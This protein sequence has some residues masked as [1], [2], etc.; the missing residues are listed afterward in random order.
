MFSLKSSW[1]VRLN[2]LQEKCIEIQ[3]EILFL[4]VFSSRLCIVIVPNE[5]H[6]MLTVCFH[7]KTKNVAFWH[8]IQEAKTKKKPAKSS[9]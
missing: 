7:N 5:T 2:R 1:P 9:C 4:S 8:F 6:N 3:L